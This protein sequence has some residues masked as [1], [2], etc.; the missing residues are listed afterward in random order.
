MPLEIEILSKAEVDAIWK[1]RALQARAENFAE[2]VAFMNARG[3]G[4]SF[5]LKVEKG[6]KNADSARSLRHNFT[7]AAKE[8][9]DTNGLPAPVM[10]RWK[11]DTHDEKRKRTVDGKPTEVEIKVIDRLTALVIAS[12]G[13]V[14][15]RTLTTEVVVPTNP[16]AGAVTGATMLLADGRTATL[17]KSGKWRAPKVS[18]TSAPVS[19]QNGVT[20]GVS[21]SGNSVEGNTPSAAWPEK[22][23]A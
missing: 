15:H 11:S 10:L 12:G 21:A 1:S 9:S 20:N 8:R 23:S 6:D 5:R 13:E 14:K 17:A 2:Y 7:E 16:P 4:D 19:A 3:V 18:V 22:A